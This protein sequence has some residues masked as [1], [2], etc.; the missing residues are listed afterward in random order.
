MPAMVGAIDSGFVAMEGTSVPRSEKVVHVPGYQNRDYEV[1]DYQMTELPG[2]GLMFRGPLPD[3]SPGKYFACVGA[4]QTMG[5]FC[6]LS[7]PQLLE[8]QLGLP[9][10]NLGY[11]GAGPEFFAN[12]PAV[13]EHVN[14]ARF[15]VLQ[16]M[17]ARSQSNSY[18][19]CGGLEYVT[20]RDNGQKL[21][22]HAAFNR[23]VWG[24]DLVAK[25]PLS[26]KWQRR[27]SNVVARPHW[28]VPGLVREVQSE[29]VRSSLALIEKIDV[30]VV[31]L[32]FSQRSPAYRQKYGTAETTLGEYPH[33]VTPQMLE[34]LRPKVAGYVECV[35]RR[36]SPQPLVSRF[37]GKPT[38]VTPAND[39]TDLGGAVW[40]TNQY[41]PSP[42]MHEDVAA[43][44][45]DYLKSHRAVLDL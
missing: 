9:A 31:L 13:L 22:A 18:Y 5:C 6:Q 17:S 28:R 24:P 32:W 39:R 16:V 12:Q 8:S 44:L 25:L 1:V 26:R 4:A 27:V 19:E 42:E 45:G 23:L 43:L 34:M 7:Y 10:L 20:L 3:L 14:R 40:H 35:S 36:G 2:T 37:T 30:P 21:G 29:W 38:T 33:L 11:G 41:Y 15:V